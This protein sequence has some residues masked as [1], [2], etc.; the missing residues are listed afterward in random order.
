MGDQTVRT[1]TVIFEPA[2]RMLLKSSPVA[3]NVLALCRTGVKFDASKKD[4][5][6]LSLPPDGLLPVARLISSDIDE[7]VR[8]QRAGWSYIRP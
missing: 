4:I 1:E 8:R 6:E 3:H 7:L 5:R 2:I